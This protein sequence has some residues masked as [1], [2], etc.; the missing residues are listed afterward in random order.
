MEEQNFDILGF[1]AIFTKKFPFKKP[2]Y[3]HY[4]FERPIIYHPEL[5]RQM[6][7]K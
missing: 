5:S 3:V 7:A 2:G 6:Y 4:Y 1:S